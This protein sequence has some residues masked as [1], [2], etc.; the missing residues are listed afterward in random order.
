MRNN[1]NTSSSSIAVLAV[2]SSPKYLEIILLLF[3]PKSYDQAAARCKLSIEAIE[4]A[5]ELSSGSSSDS[6]SSAGDVEV[7]TREKNEIRQQQL[8]KRYSA[9]TNTM[10]DYGVEVTENPR[11]SMCYTATT[12]TPFPPPRQSI[13]NT[14][15]THKSESYPWIGFSSSCKQM[16][17]WHVHKK[18][19]FTEIY[20]LSCVPSH[21]VV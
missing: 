4:T 18:I 10:M 16:T 6:S 20:F 12:P 1:N 21:A 11:G 9:L 19:Y 2:V 5:S 3:M 15:F 14:S 8:T 7:S 17:L 13:S